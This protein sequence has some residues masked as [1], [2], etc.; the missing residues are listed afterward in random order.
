MIEPI[1]IIEQKER[2]RNGTLTSARL[3]ELAQRLTRRGFILLPSDTGYSLAAL[4]SD[5]NSSKH[6]NTILNRENEPVSLAFPS[7][8]SVREGKWVEL[9]PL[10]TVLIE[11]FTPGPITIVC[12]VSPTPPAK[13]LDALGSPRQTIGVRIP[14]SVVE[15]DVAGATRWPI[16]TVGIRDPDKPD[17]IVKSFSRALEIVASG[18]ERLGRIGWSAIEGGAFYDSHS[19][20]VD[21]SNGSGELV[22]RREGYLPF[23]RIKAVQRLPSIWSFEDIE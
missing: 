22:L 12:K 9:N 19:T 18:A 8:L 5:D 13:I 14:D 2:T 3:E 1:S 15:R 7:Y 10:A 6:I 23:E 21:V 17:E 20:V 16:T 11:H 4:V